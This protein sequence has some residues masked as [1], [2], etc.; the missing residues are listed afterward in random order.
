MMAEFANTELVDVQPGRI[1]SDSTPTM[2]TPLA[3]LATPEAT[4]IGFAA[5]SATAVALDAATKHVV[6][7]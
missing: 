4:P 2:I 1:G 7:H 5:T 6:H 3:A